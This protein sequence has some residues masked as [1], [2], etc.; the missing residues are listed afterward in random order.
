MKL[1]TAISVIQGR[2]ESYPKGSFLRD[3]YDTV[4][5]AAAQGHDEKPPFSSDDEFI[6]WIAAYYPAPGPLVS[7]EQYSKNRESWERFF[8]EIQRGDIK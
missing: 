6:H 7:E 4:L 3:A 5:Y 1:S 8:A 2:A